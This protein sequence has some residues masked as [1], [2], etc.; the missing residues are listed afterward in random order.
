MRMRVGR[1]IIVLR[2]AEP[3]TKGGH[4]NSMEELTPWTHHADRILVF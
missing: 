3:I 4:K 1:K 2:K